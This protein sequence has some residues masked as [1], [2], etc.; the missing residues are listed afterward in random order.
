MTKAD[1]ERVAKAYMK[2]DQFVILV[3]GKEK[4][5]EAPLASLGKVTRIDITIPK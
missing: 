1:V 2:S 3:L 5:F 4:D